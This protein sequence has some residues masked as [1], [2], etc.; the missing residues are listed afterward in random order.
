MA[1][2][3]GM[4]NVAWSADVQRR[5]AV[6]A[7]GAPEQVCFVLHEGAGHAFDNPHPDLHHA[8]ASEAAWRQT[9]DVLAEVL[10]ARG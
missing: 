9:L 6:T 10:P 7:G 3:P 8:A 2:P 4:S 5:K 1:R